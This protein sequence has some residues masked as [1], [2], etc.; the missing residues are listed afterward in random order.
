MY[1]KVIYLTLSLFLLCF[2]ACD[3]QIPKEIL[4]KGNPNFWF[5]AKLDIGDLLTGTFQDAIATNEEMGIISCANTDNQTFL[6]HMNLFN[7]DLVF[8]E[9]PTGS[10]LLPDDFDVVFGYE[11]PPG[12]K[13]LVNTGEPLDLPLGDL[14][15]FLDGFSFQN[16]KT[17]LYFSG[18]SIVSKLSIGITI[19]DGIEEV[20]NLGSSQASNWSNWKVNGYNDE[21]PPTGGNDVIIPLEGEDVSISFRVFVPGGETLYTTDFDNAFINVELVVWLPLEFKADGDGAIIDLP[22]DF[23]PVSGD[24][25]GRDDIDSTNMVGDIVDSLAL[26]IQFN[27]NP[28]NGG[29]LIVRSQPTDS[30]DPYTLDQIIISNELSG[31]EFCFEINED[32]MELIN[33]TWPFAPKFEILF[34]AGDTVEIPRDFSANRFGFRA[35][36]NFTIELGGF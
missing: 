5:S 11:V 9:F 28:F 2:F 10:D 31:N 27:R 6:I 15:G 25:F 21:T 1:K 12:G 29:M 4:V 8:G 19:N 34:N 35:A 32:N 16:Y 7:E 13:N 23:L 14:S 17:L 3:L 18:S 22:P 30:K 33:N 24:L 26:E 36:L 20:I